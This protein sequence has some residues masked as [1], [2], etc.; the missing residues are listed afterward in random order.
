LLLIGPTLLTLEEDAV[1]GPLK[2]CD[3]LDIKARE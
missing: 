1:H 2:L 3:Y